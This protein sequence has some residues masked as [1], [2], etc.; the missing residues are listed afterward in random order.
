[1]RGSRQGPRSRCGQYSGVAFFPRQ[2]VFCLWRQVLHFPALHLSLPPF[3][4]FLCWA[5]PASFPPS[6][7]PLLPCALRHPSTLS[8]SLPHPPLSTFRLLLL[9]TAEV[10]WVLPV[11]LP[12]K[13]EQRQ[14]ATAAQLINP[15][16]PP[17][18]SHLPLSADCRYDSAR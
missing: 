11:R 4:F 8:P 5:V 7:P 18:H 13:V 16:P 14:G 2:L 10:D 9:Q 12:S 3:T 17:Y 15:S 1:M 6:F